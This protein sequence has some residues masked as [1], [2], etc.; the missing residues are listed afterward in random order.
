MNPDKRKIGIIA[1][2]VCDL[3]KAT[4]QNYDIDVL[5]FLIETETGIFTDTDEITAEN[6]L[7]Y[8]ESGGKKT[9]SS[10]PSPDVY[11]KAFEKKLKKCEEIILVTISS[12][13]SPSFENAKKAAALVENGFDKIHVID[14]GHLSS[15]LGFL[16]MHAA[17]M[18][19]KGYSADK[20]IP[21]LSELKNRISTTFMTRNADYLYRNQL[22]PK[23][24]KTLCSA[25]N[26][27]PVLKMKNGR[28]TLKSFIFGN[29]N[30]ACKKY[31]RRELKNNYKIDK[32]RAFVT[33]V[34]C[35]VKMLRLIT[36]EINKNCQF[37]TLNI[38]SA[39]ATISSNCGPGT[40]GV[41][42]ITNE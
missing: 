17:E 34:G 14:S 24:M 41:L 42:F 15:G 28:I 38:T 37:E 30:Y 22:V 29:Y 25:F 16:V 32:K 7:S 13:I 26:L 12:C 3:P 21:E 5:Y 1:E 36:M 4:I 31:V 11:K 40:F 18:A 33:H 19:E 2:C 8:M 6:I 35:S 20:I 27:H 23:I 10:P 9:K 39:S